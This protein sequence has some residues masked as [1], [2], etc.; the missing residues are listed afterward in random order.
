MPHQDRT[1]TKYERLLAASLLHLEYKLNG[2][3]GDNY[4]HPRPRS[5]VIIPGT[6]IQPDLVVRRD[7]NIEATL[8]ATHWSRQRNSNFKFWR[9]WEECA[10]QK[11][12]LNESLLSINCVFEALP[13]G[14]SPGLYVTSDELP[15]D[16]SRNGQVPIGLN[17]WYSATSWA[18]I[19]AFDVTLLFPSRYAP[20]YAVTRFDPG[21]HDT[22][23]TRLLEQA[24]ARPAKS[25]LFS[26]WR[27]LKEI[28]NRANAALPN[29]KDTH[30]RYRVGLLHVY[31]F[32]RLVDRALG[33]NGLHLQDFIGDLV[34]AG[35]EVI[36]LDR[37]ADTRS[38]GELGLQ[39]MREL[40]ERLSQIYVG[41]GQNA[42]R[43]C[44]FNTFS[45]PDGSVSIHRVRFNS[46]LK[47][48]LQDL[49]QHVDSEGFLEVLRQAFSRF[50][51]AYRI[52]EAI[53]DLANPTL[54]EQKQSFVRERFAGALTD[55]DTLNGLLQTH[56]K[57]LSPE[58][59]AISEDGQNWVLE[60]LLYFRNIELAEDIYARFTA[61]F[62]QS[63]H[64]LRPHAP[65]GDYAKTIGFLLQGRDICE[66][67]SVSG[68]QRTLSK[69]EF[70]TLTWQAIAKSIT[71]T[72]QDTDNQVASREEVIR[73]YLESK[74]MRVISADLNG[75]HIMLTHSL[76]D[77]CH[78]MF[79]DAVQDNSS[80]SGYRI[81]PSWQTEVV[82]RL[83][84]GRPL[85]T[86]LEGESR[87]GEWLIKVQSSQYGN[88]GHKSKELS[89]RCRSTRLAW[90]PIEDSRN[91]SEW[92]FTE[93]NMKK[94][95]LVLDGDWDTSNKRNLYEA[96]WDWVGDVSEL[97][98]LR[99][100]IEK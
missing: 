91:R 76:G 56:A 35:D 64:R 95:A 54:V 11:V 66:Q 78:F 31:L 90:L 43:F 5:Q 68:G 7:S 14:M 60:M 10:Q 41:R 58:R 57:Q 71:Q 28:R 63:G 99:E 24:L 59:A 100:L 18:M 86:W 17:G 94:L 9:T 27:T 26:Q 36:R 92:N 84:S 34:G 48:C 2:H 4:L 33:E 83:W 75:F 80:Q 97:T 70:R 82:N 47:L 79:D 77:I 88:E 6:Y 44:T 51:Q 3:S 98:D 29:L 69:E 72:V 30:S 89:G 74:A 42:K 52:D 23:T 32:Y 73:K 81:L 46:D 21:E 53:D 39:R 93:R 62:E 55:E 45:H 13:A 25:Y 65:Y 19:E 8:Y 20:V 67:W 61:N 40:F 16:L 50:D 96:G 22:E 15:A 1:G 87:N 85:E 12:A 37:L 38:F 49:R